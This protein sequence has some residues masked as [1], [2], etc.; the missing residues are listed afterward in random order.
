MADY[1]HECLTNSAINVRTF[2]QSDRGVK[3]MPVNPRRLVVRGLARLERTPGAAGQSILRHLL[4]GPD[5]RELDVRDRSLITSCF[6][7]VLRWRI[8][9]DSHIAAHARKG[10]PSDP[11]L[12]NIL[13]LG[14]FQLLF[15]DRVPARAAV[16]TSVSLARKL[17]GQAVGK[18]VNGVLR[19][20][21][22]HREPP[23][24][25]ATRYGHPAW[26]V[27]RLQEHL[28]DTVEAR[29]KA[30]MTPPPVHLRVHPNAKHKTDD[31]TAT[32]HPDVYIASAEET[33]SRM[34]R[35]GIREGLWLPQ[36]RASVEVCDLLA[37]DT[38][39]L[40]MLEL[41]CGRGVKTTRFLEK[42]QQMG[43]QG[44]Y[45]AVDASLPRLHEANRL[46]DRWLPAHD[47]V[48]I[49]ADASAA[50]PIDP[51]IQFDRIIID[52]PCSGLGVIRR[53]PEILWRRSPDD[54]AT[55]AALQ[56]DIVHQAAARLRPGGQLVY[57]VCTRTPEE[58]TSVVQDLASTSDLHIEREVDFSPEVDGCD[59]FYAARMK[60]PG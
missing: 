19:S 10:V 20:I 12:A 15:L 24:D 46:C 4:D 31:L 60:K 30:N 16:H 44:H 3:Q 56:R 28:G 55:L 2:R 40:D 47:A 58:T 57:A 59:G 6:Y 13:R 54:I 38:T 35:Q 21:D 29:L 50:L 51:E 1:R 41:C 48:F 23:S 8:R 49:A 9:L 37:I 26:M 14:V 27:E 43:T 11:E 42:R 5:A 33:G 32:T 25:L 22:R 52:A 34:I 39:R 36:D 53:R 7:G 17:R 45:I 18:F